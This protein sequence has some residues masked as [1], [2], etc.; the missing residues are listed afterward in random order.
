M[1]LSIDTSTN[2]AG[3]AI[4]DQGKPIAERTWHSI[5]NHTIELIPGIQDMLKQ[6]KIELDNIQA[7]FVA[8][9]P[10]SFNGLR[11]GISTAKGFALALNIPV[12]A[13]S[14]LEIEAYHFAFTRLL[15]CPIHSAGRG[16]IATALYLQNN[17]WKCIEKEH[18]TTTEVLCQQIREETIFC[19]E[20][21][22]PDVQYLQQVL[23]NYAIIPNAT[24][25]LRHASQLATLGWQ[26]LS[27]GIQDNP[28][29]LQPIYLRKPPITQ[30]KVK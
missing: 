20:I 18:I 21:P 17:L 14:T 27:A 6:M 11:V 16:E 8:K 13:I 4:S 9:G 24:V 29:S 12:V 7:I 25:L 28:E 2:Y 15:L 1:E 10:G 22:P 26:R 5:Q 23:G 3:I 19:G 30:R